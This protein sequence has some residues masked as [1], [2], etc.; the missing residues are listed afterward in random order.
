MNIARA[1][2]FEDSSTGEI[3]EVTIVRACPPARSREKYLLGVSRD[4]FLYWK[5]ACTETHLQ[6]FE[7]IAE[8][9]TYSAFAKYS[10][11]GKSTVELLTPAKADKALAIKAFKEFFERQTGKKWEERADGKAPPPKT[12]K[13]GNGL[14][15][16]EGWYALEATGNW[17]TDWMKAY[18]TPSDSAD[19]DTAAN[20]PSES[21]PEE[22]VAAY[23]NQD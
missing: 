13:D 16:H 10:R 22:N 20:A 19:N 21:G 18:K 3:W 17:F 12:D 6:I 2:I 9:H 7:T 1:K 8:P 11:V 4:I 23:G 15:V 5:L 14:P